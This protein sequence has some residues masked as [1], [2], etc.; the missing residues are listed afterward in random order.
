MLKNPIYYH[1]LFKK[2]ISLFGT[3]F[4]DIKIS[5]EDSTGTRVS[6]IPVPIM[7][8]PKEKMIARVLSDPSIDRPYAISLPAMSFEMKGLSYDGDR[9]LNTI[10]KIV[11]QNRTTGKMRTIYNPVPYNITW[12]LKVYSKNAE[13][14][15][16]IVEQ[17]L[18][19][20]TPDWTPTVELI[21]ELGIK[22]DIPIILK[23]VEYDDH[24]DDDFDKRRVMIWTLTFEMKSY[25]YGPYTENGVIKFVKNNFYISNRD[26][27]TDIGDIPVS[28]R[29]TVQPGLT[30][31]GE[32]TSKIDE[33]IPYLEINSDD[34][35]GFITIYTSIEDIND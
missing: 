11:S 1:S 27:I 7:Y 8:A 4:N 3:I 35:Y 13:D 29:V 25:F 9:K 22:T 32:P 21:P 20:F 5:R 26:D 16:K 2:Y 19:F 31:N 28:E 30:A 15:L 10:G 12:E 17:I 34:D 23:S 24:Y 33:T 14:S 6:M 18:P